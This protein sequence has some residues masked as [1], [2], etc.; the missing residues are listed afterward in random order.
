MQTAGRK[1]QT[2]S[3]FI[4]SCTSI[5]SCSENRET[6]KTFPEFVTARCKPNSRTPHQSLFKM[7]KEGRLD[8]VGNWRSGLG[9]AYPHFHEDVSVSVP[10][11]WQCLTSLTML[12]FHPPSSNSTFSFPEY[13][14]PIIFFQRLSQPPAWHSGIV[15]SEIT[16]T[17]PE[18]SAF[19]Q[20]P[21]S[22]TR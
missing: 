21:F 6:A 17:S 1:V 10:F 16:E 7:P 9:L 5:Y 15:S 18:F 3:N 14:F 11:V 22:E 20:S 19:L 12:Y 13:G 2:I 8:S 4:S